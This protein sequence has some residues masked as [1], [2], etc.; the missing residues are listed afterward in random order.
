[1]QWK[2]VENK[3]KKTGTWWVQYHGNM[4]NMFH[5]MLSFHPFWWCGYGLS[6]SL[7]V[8][9]TLITTGHEG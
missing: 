1:M 2:K 9:P 5:F 6:V 8:L 3:W 4:W 7:T